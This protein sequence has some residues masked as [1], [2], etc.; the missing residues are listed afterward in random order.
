MEN[1]TRRMPA[2]LLDEYRRAVRHQQK[3]LVPA[4]D[5]QSRHALRGECSRLQM[6]RVAIVSYFLSLAQAPPRCGAVSRVDLNTHAIQVQRLRR[7]QRRPDA[8][9]GIQH[10]PTR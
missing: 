10:Q 7:Q 9:E 3:V 1:H 4:F 5:R 8:Q 2:Q 6:L